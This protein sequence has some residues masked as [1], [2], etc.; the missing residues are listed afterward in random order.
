MRIEIDAD[1]MPD[2]TVTGIHFIDSDDPA[3]VTTLKS[4]SGSAV[5]QQQAGWSLTSRHPAA[6][7]GETR[8]TKL[9]R[10]VNSAAGPATLKALNLK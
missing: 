2:G 10:F 1:I 7:P 4:I 3:V 9:L 8:W 6:L 5:L